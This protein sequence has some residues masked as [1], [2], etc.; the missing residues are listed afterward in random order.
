[1]SI[2]H[3]RNT[4]CNRNNKHTNKTDENVALPKF[5]LLI[6]YENVSLTAASL[7]KTKKSTKNPSEV[8]RKSK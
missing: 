3:S 1:V 5:W 8:L 4:N 6:C 2:R 7:K